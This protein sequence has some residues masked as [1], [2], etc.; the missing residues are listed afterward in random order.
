M[1][2]SDKRALTRVLV[3]AGVVAL[4]DQLSKLAAG[5]WL[6][7]D[8]GLAP[9]LSLTLVH[10]PAGPLGVSLGA[11][12]RGLNAVLALVTIGLVLAVARDLARAVRHATLAL[13][14][15]AGASLGNLLSLAITPAGVPDFVAV[16]ARGKGIVINVADIAAY[17]GVVLLVVA[18][19]RLVTELRARLRV[20]AE[21]V[22]PAAAVLALRTHEREV[23]R[24]VF[25]EG[26]EPGAPAR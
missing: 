20:R 23:V 8:V 18:A 3:T 11:W 12:T 19:F 13:G 21:H 16:E 9:G 5:L 1:G 17:A 15:I 6:H 14:L 26:T 2:T 4:I 24:Q 25:V 10:N 7:G 22:R